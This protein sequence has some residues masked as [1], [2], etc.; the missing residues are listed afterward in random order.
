MPIKIKKR[1]FL[2]CPLLSTAIF[3]H[4][5]QDGALS[6]PHILHIMISAYRRPKNNMF[7]N[8]VISQ[9]GRSGEFSNHKELL[10]IK[11][12]CFKG[13]PILVS[14]RLNEIIYMA[15][16]F[17]SPNFKPEM[18]FPERLSNCTELSI[19]VKFSV[20]SEL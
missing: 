17:F 16:K 6:M 19:R 8:F 18:N 10:D 9:S 11:Y 13:E 3:T 14:F 4:F 2:G 12:R 20:F 1:V 15:R 7:S 5:D